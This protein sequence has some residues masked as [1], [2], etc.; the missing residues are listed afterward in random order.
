MAGARHALVVIMLVVKKRALF[1]ARVGAG[2]EAVRLEV[3]ACVGVEGRG[4]V[5]SLGV[6]GGEGAGV[7]HLGSLEE[8]VTAASLVV[9]A[10]RVR[11]V[12][13]VL[14]RVQKALVLKALVQGR[15]LQSSKKRVARTQMEGLGVCCQVVVSLQ[16]AMV[17]RK[18]RVVMQTGSGR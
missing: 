13:V 9:S 4:V 8:A 17:G 7:L 1:R 3:V 10:V 18:V 15:R 14:V 6:V 2:G 16:Q 5:V 11:R 12:L